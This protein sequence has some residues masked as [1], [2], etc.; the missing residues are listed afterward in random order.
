MPARASNA[1]AIPE[2]TGGADEWRLRIDLAVAYRLVAA[3]GMGNR[4]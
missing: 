1:Y 4:D 2:K 3:Y